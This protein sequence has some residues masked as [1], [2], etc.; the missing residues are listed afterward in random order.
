M[1]IVAGV[2]C[3]RG[4]LRGGVGGVAGGAFGAGDFGI[5]SVF[6]EELMLGIG[7]MDP[8]LRVANLAS[9][10]TRLLKEKER[11]LSVMFQSSNNDLNYSGFE[12]GMGNAA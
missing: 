10:Q 5:A 6:R 2:D 12:R 1:G 3:A 9:G 4:S 11:R 8:L 7:D